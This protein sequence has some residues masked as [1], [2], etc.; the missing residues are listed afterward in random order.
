MKLLLTYHF[1]V[2]LTYHSLQSGL[3]ARELALDLD[4]K[5]IVAVIDNVGNHSVC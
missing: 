1:N 2:L 5:D 4:R 3:N